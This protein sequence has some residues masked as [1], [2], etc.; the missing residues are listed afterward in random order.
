MDGQP[1]GQ[2]P[3]LYTLFTP[4]ARVT[5]SEAFI[6]GAQHGGVE[7]EAGGGRGWAGSGSAAPLGA[8]QRQYLQA[9]RR[10]EV[11]RPRRRG[12][13]HQQR[14]HWQR[15]VHLPTCRQ[16][17]IDLVMLRQLLVTMTSAD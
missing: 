17:P 11:H 15:Q 5:G 16:G 1:V 13:R 10:R 12:P 3:T 6:L 8:Q 9:R 14:R 4:Q 7:A 2:H